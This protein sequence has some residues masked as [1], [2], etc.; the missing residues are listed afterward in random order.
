M[1]QGLYT[2]PTPREVDSKVEKVKALGANRVMSGSRLRVVMEVG[3]GIMKARA[4]EHPLSLLEFQANILFRWVEVGSCREWD[5]ECKLSRVSF[6]NSIGEEVG[7]V[8]SDDSVSMGVGSLGD[9]AFFPLSLNRKTFLR[10]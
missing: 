7:E 8:E 6:S 2:Q 5:P 4:L 1:S 9:E 3:G 10:E